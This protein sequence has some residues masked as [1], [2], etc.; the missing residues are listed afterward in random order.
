MIWGDGLGIGGR[1]HIVALNFLQNVIWLCVIWMCLKMS[2][3]TAKLQFSQGKSS[4]TNVFTLGRPT[5]RPIHISPHLKVSQSPLNQ[6][7]ITNERLITIIAYVQFFTIPE[8]QDQSLWA[9]VQD[10]TCQVPTSI[11]QRLPGTGKR[12]NSRGPCAAA[13][14]NG[15]KMA[16]RPVT[17]PLFTTKVTFSLAMTPL[18]RRLA[19][20]EMEIVPP[21]NTAISLENDHR[22]YWIYRGHPIVRETQFYRH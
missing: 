8:I 5:F 11:F 18:K 20:F 6:A 3:Y 22:S 13:M 14:R 10:Q 4:L 19:L 15:T 2:A 7:S 21:P 17:M 1:D 9:Q 16:N 12:W